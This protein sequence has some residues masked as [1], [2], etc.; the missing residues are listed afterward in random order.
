MTFL[1]TALDEWAD[2][3]TKAHTKAGDTVP[4]NSSFY[5]HIVYFHAIESMSR[6]GVLLHTLSQQGME[7]V[8]KELNRIWRGSTNHDGGL[9]GPSTLMQMV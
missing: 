6:Q 9:Q 2:A 7:A 5:M 8:N 1:Q 3:W 4:S